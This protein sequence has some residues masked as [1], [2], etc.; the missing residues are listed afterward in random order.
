MESKFLVSELFMQFNK[1]SCCEH[2]TSGVNI[3][4]YGCASLLAPE[5][6]VC[7]CVFTCV[8]VCDIKSEYQKEPHYLS[9]LN[10]SINVIPCC[11]ENTSFW[12]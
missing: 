6:A 8:W 3:F 1:D 11:I 10:N 7:L 5:C 9:D 12:Y 4:L 2:I